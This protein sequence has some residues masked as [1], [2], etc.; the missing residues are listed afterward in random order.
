[1]SPEKLIRMA[2][3]IATFFRTKPHEEAVMGVAEHISNFWEPRMRARLFDLLSDNCQGLDP[4]VIEAKDYIR[5]V[6]ENA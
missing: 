2:N 3:Q 5:P 6:E 4:L 1:M